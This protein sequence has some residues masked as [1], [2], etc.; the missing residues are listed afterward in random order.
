[1]TA[2]D[3]QVTLGFRRGHHYNSARFELAVGQSDT[4]RLPVLMTP[5]SKPG[6]DDISQE[7]FDGLL[8]WLDPERDKAGLKYESIRKRLIKI[9]VCR[10]SDRPEELADRTIN[11]VARKLPE[12]R[13][14]FVG[15]PAHY[16]CGVASNIF[17][18]SLKNQ[19]I[20]AARPVSPVLPDADDE[21]DYACLEQCVEKLSS[22]D[23]DLVLQYYQQEKH[24]KIEHRKKLAERLGLAI[25]A[26][27][28]RAC[29]TRAALLECVERCRSESS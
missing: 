19:K 10:G 27:R 24:A 14:S 25:N 4:R 23:R 16:F 21:R 15:E 3:L 6:S 9:F 7:Q 1:M 12:I 22:F 5:P 2:H 18:E 20:P 13:A 8:D 28:I 26:L 29:R 11:R 17:R